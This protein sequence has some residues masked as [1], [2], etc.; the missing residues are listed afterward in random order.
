MSNFE[1][2]LIV[3]ACAVPV[4]ALLFVLPKFKKKE[5]KAP[6]PTKTYEEIKKEEQVEIKSGLPEEKKVQTFANND[7]SPEDFKGYLNHKQK[8]ITR[9]SRVNLPKDFMDRTE[10]Y[11]PRRRRRMEEK[12]KSVADEIRSLSPEL[13]ALIIAGVLDKKDFN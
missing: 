1:I 4:V 2:V 5:Q 12:P 13:K 9:P 8:N 10:P 6:V 7:F 3:L 11:M